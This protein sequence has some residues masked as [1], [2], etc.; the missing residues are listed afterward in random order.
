M[1]LT[2]YVPRLVLD[3][4]RLMPDVAARTVDGTLVFADVS[5]FTAMSERLARFGK[6]GAEEVTW[7]I[8]HVFT[9]MLDVAYGA[10]GGLLK[11]GG[12][13]VLLLFEGDDHP[14]RGASA[15]H[16]MRAAIRRAG[17]LTTTAGRVTLRVST[18]VHSGT[19]D[20]ALLGERHREL[21][22]LGP[23]VTCT[24]AMEAAAS[25][26]EIVV[27]AATASAL[28]PPALGTRVGEGFLL[29]RAPALHLAPAAAVER[30]EGLAAPYIPAA[31]RRH[32]QEGGEAPEHRASTIGFLH[33]AG[34]DAIRGPARDVVVEGLREVVDLTN[35]VADDHGVAVLGSDVASDGVKL[36]LAAGAPMAVA[37]HDERMLRAVR[38]IVDRA[39]A[40]PVRA[41]VHRGHVFAGPVGPF[42]RRTYTVMGDAVNTAARAMAIANPAD[43]VATTDVIARSSIAF[44][45]EPLPPVPVKG[46]REP[47]IVHRIGQPIGTA[48][49][50]AGLGSMVGRAEELAA[51]IAAADA[52]A[53]G[54]GTAIEISAEAGTGK[55]RLITELC[56][57]IDLPVFTV[58]GD[59]YA[60]TMAFQPWTRLLDGLLELPS[61]RD[62]RPPALE[63]RVARLDPTLLP[64]L[65]LL[66]AIT[67]VDVPMTPDV[68]R[69]DDRFRAS[70][71]HDV[72]AQLLSH[73]LPRPCLI[74]FDETHLMDEPSV[75]LLRHC[76]ARCEQ[77]GWLLIATGRS[78]TFPAALPAA[79]LELGALP[80]EA[81]SDLAKEA[82]AGSL[83]ASEAERVA[84][85]AG[86][87]PM[88]ILELVRAAIVGDESLSA[89]V[90]ESIAARIDRL[91]AQDRHL[92]RQLAVLGAPRLDDLD[93]LVEGADIDPGTWRRLDGFVEVAGG[94]VTF[95]QP[96]LR[97]V[98]YEGLPFSL[99]KRIHARAGYRLEA[100]AAAD[101]GDADAIADALS[102]HFHEAGEHD[103]S[104]RYSRIAAERAWKKHAHL[105]AAR[106]LR[107]ALVAA[108][109]LE[110][111][112]RD[113]FA[114]A[115]QELG[116]ALR[117]GGMMEEATQAYAEA[118]RHAAD[119][120]ALA[121]LH[122]LEAGARQLT[123]QFGPALRWARRGQ[124]LLEAVPDGRHATVTL[125][126][127]THVRPAL[128][129]LAAEGLARY[130]QRRMAQAERILRRGLAEAEEAFDLGAVALISNVLYL[131]LRAQRSPAAAEAAQRAVDVAQELDNV[132]LQGN[133]LNSLAIERH[134]RGAWNEAVELYERTRKLQEQ[135]G[136]DVGAA[137]VANNLAEILSDQGHLAEAVSAFEDAARTLRA[138]GV[139]PVELPVV[140]NLVRALARAGR[141][142]DA[143]IH[144]ERARDLA[145]QLDVDEPALVLR[146]A[147]VLVAEGGPDA[148]LAALA[149]L[150][151]T[152]EREPS[153]PDITATAALVRA[154]ALTALGRTAEAT[155]TLVSALDGARAAGLRYELA[156]LLDE[157][158][159]TDP[160]RP[161]EQAEADAM[162]AALGVVRTPRDGALS[163]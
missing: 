153:P 90:E 62:S 136:S 158:A 34:T 53:E 86:G 139:R 130:S 123:G 88:F 126:D 66:G 42:Y 79:R 20:M 132:M 154:R 112:P 70:R 124:R 85:R 113:E 24:V 78:P 92:L 145:L 14:A 122:A 57:T 63:Q 37:D 105:P 100:T 114:K 8:D 73:V 7:G 33:V 146:T 101:A 40:M 41:G 137:I 54:R 150:D 35:E 104:W 25:A 19:F 87:H 75:E 91:L 51:L 65:P 59:T 93:A 152:A 9:E 22:V 103:R 48:E 39:T 74:W 111:V 69:L 149:T 115:W 163:S 120:V 108:S 47:L 129:L 68:A 60:G 159:A 117:L 84:A 102:L 38:A 148:A 12:D 162:L 31:I 116:E 143:R 109:R 119:P 98:A 133:V 36:I 30:P 28:A 15:A 29:R 26:G 13:A 43:V 156:V 45:A 82:A 94:T 76:A 142:D 140:L 138:A 49:T 16:G 89:S 18:G 6:I 21:L 96:L 17:R 71:L 64:W 61:D 10:G 32:L 107:R 110:S 2:P 55:T 135:A 144:L 1:D 67:D 46:K 50:D 58:A 77:L 95:R 151:A 5:G 52:T 157:L 127:G 155:D 23:D 72:A 4:G 11:F 118:R 44:E 56:A 3:W 27:S 83:V 97:D 121:H 128:R 99:R 160:P 81:A 131:V 161:D 106:L 141:T 80:P 147:E 134:E 125:R